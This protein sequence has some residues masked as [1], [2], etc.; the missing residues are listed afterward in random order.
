[1]NFV[2]GSLCPA[3]V[4]VVDVTAPSVCFPIAPLHRQGS[5]HKNK[6]HDRV[7]QFTHTRCS[8]YILLAYPPANR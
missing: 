1:M 7:A 5:D 6:L 8:T 3:D 4:L 2:A